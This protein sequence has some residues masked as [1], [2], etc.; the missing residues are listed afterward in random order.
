MGDDSNGHLS[1]DGATTTA[2]A[3][4]RPRAPSA[5]IPPRGRPRGLSSSSL[6]WDGYE[7]DPAPLPDD[8]YPRVIPDR[9]RTIGFYIALI[10][11]IGVWAITP[12]S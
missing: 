4:R 8:V 7:P 6:V 3:Y 1:P 5:P 10:P 11:I 12:A 2:P 9:R